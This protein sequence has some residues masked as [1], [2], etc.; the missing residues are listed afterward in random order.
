[1]ATI[2]ALLTA[3]EYF[4]LP[5]QGRPSELVRGK[6][7]M[8]NMPGFRHGL[9]CSAIAAALRNFVSDRDLGRVVTNDA[10]VITERG[11]D[12]VRGADVAFYSFARLPKT[13]VPAG[14][15][16]VAPELVFEVLSPS[17]RWPDVL[18]KV[19]EYLKAGVL[20]VCIV[21]PEREVVIVHDAEHPG[22]T[23]AAGDELAL[24]EWIGGWRIGVR[25]FFE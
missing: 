7:V 2:E 24:P 14:Y 9:V 10:G 17:D 13:S 18:A 19:S 16:G 23:L 8:M 25:Q 12:T 15:P 5:D 3:E 6:I 20:A 1:M 4:K 11:P 21:D 22:R